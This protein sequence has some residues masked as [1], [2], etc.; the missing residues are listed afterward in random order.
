M[1]EHAEDRQDDFTDFVKRTAVL[2]GA[3]LSTIALMTA[4]W[5]WTPVSLRSD[6]DR[7][8]KTVSRVAAIVELQAVIQSEDP[9][10]PEREA[11]LNELRKLRR[12]AVSE[13]H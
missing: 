7:L 5:R 10:S 8:D 4:L 1:S 3:A 9:G 13:V 6:V 12:V 11:A 2:L